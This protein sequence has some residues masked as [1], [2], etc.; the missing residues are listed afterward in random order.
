MSWT[1]YA[2]A[3]IAD[4]L[5]FGRR[6]RRLRSERDGCGLRVRPF[7]PSDP[8]GQAAYEHAFK[9]WCEQCKAA[10]RFAYTG[11]VR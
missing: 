10:R 1:D 2:L 9:C 11:L 4:D 5:R 6:P 7:V 8:G 3:H